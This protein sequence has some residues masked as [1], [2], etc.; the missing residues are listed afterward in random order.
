MQIV[1]VAGP[2]RAETAEMRARNIRLAGGVAIMLWSEGF[3]ALCPHR[4]SA[5]MDGAVPDEEFLEGSLEMLRRCDAVLMMP[6]WE[7]SEG[8]VAERD[9]AT[10]MNIPVFEFP[11]FPD[12]T[13]KARRPQ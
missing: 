10:L 7:K 3:A 13:L 6:G 1:Y 4:N 5:N 8:S 12:E 11:N 9:T 2:Y